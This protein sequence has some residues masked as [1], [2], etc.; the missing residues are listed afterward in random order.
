MRVLI[1]GYVW[2]E[3]NSSAAGT[4][5]VEL[6]QAFNKADWEVHFASAATPTQHQVDVQQLHVTAHNIA[7]NCSSFNTFLT[8]LLPDIVVFDRFVSEEQFGWRVAE[9][10]P[11]ALRVLDTEDLHSL[12]QTRESLLK[13][14]Q[15][16]HGAGA[17][18]ITAQ[19][20]ELYSAMLAQGTILREVAAIL[21]SD[22]SLVISDTEIALLRELFSVPDYLLYHLPFML[23]A[24]Q[25]TATPGFDQRQGFISLGN[26]RHAPNWDAV[27]WLKQ[28]L[29]PLIRAR[30]PGA[31]LSVCGAYP[32]PKVT[33]LHNKR[34]GFLV[35]GWVENSQATIAQHRVCLAPLR[36]GA[37][38]KGKLIDAMQTATPSVTTSIGAEAMQGDLPWPGAIA[39]APE[40]FADNAVRLHQH[41]EDWQ[42]ASECATP[43][44]HTRYNGPV[45]GQQL[46][47]ALGELKR[48]LASHR[49]RHFLGQLMN[50]HT[51]RSSEFMSRWI[52]AKSRPSI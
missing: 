16:Q 43:L 22:I 52:E 32:P 31:R 37:G 47:D 38:I 35:S 24:K 48:A 42:A 30:L 4:R 19:G 17:L 46:T 49:Q 11:D 50:H 8:Q 26:F 15:A 28:V 9:A 5:I 12:R 13:A 18:P 25:I 51:L 7:L 23:T 2:P 20:P 3:P 36:V 27:L 14:A 40:A 45:L 41:L 33:A 39:D 1:I 34:E 10:V 29:W 44:L 21:R 6:M